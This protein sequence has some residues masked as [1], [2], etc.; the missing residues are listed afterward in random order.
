MFWK[1]LLVAA[2]LVSG[3]GF[4]SDSIQA[5]ADAT[6]SCTPGQYDMVD[7]MVLDSSMRTG[8]HLSGSSNPLYS[9]LSSGKFYWTKGG[10]GYPSD[11]QLFDD[12][13]IYLWITELD[14]N[15]PTTFK[16]FSYNTNM[17]LAPRCASGGFPGSTIRVPDT[18]Y[19][20]YTDCSHH[21][22]HTL[23]KGINEVWGPYN[24]SLGGN[25]PANTPTLVVSY[26]YNCDNGY[27]NCSDKEEYYLQQKHG[28]VQ[29]IHYT[30]NKGKYEQQ[31]K[32]VFNKLV[33]GSVPP[34]FQCF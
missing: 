19:D 6:T 29:W 26:R 10:R 15:D 25:L 33:A 3:L 21:T 28:L 18:S 7:W 13:Y 17:P 20:I 1:F 14:W 30:L 24:F 9:E 32:S 16:K 34:K 4:S 11:I 2:L 27:A 22:Q 8:G 5:L 12:K 31:Q 23:R